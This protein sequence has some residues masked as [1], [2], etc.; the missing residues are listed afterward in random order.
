MSLGR[1]DFNIYNLQGSKLVTLEDVITSSA[2]LLKRDVR[3]IE[4]NPEKSEYSNCFWKQGKGRV[5]I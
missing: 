2:Q 4:S 3:I 1:P 5:G